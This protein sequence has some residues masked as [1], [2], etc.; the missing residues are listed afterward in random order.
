MKRLIIAVLVLAAVLMIQLTIVNGIA[1]PGGGIPDLVLLCVIAIGLTSGPEAGLAAGF[2]AGLALDLAPPAHQLVGQY[3]L[4][5]CLIGY[6][7]GR[8]WFTL[9]VSA[10]LALGVAAVAAV[11][12][13]VLTAGL[14]VAL[15]TP[16]VTLSAVAQTLP[17]AA[18]YDLG[19]SP[20]VLFLAVRLAVA[21][22]ANVGPADDS[23]AAEPGGSAQPGGLAGPGGLR[24][25]RPALGRGGPGLASGSWLTGDAAGEAGAVGA[26]GWLSGPATSRRARRE[27]ARLTAMVTGAAARKGAFWVG[28][29][30]DGLTPGPA[31]RA[32]CARSHRPA[33]L[34]PGDGVAG[35]A[36]RAG[37]PHPV[38]PSRPV[39]LRLAEQQRKNAARR[40][41]GA[42]ART[43]AGAGGSG[44]GRMGADVMGLGGHGLD[45][46]G[47]NGPG[48]PRIAFGTGSLPGAGRVQRSG[49]P[50]IAFGTGSLAAAGGRTAC[51][52]SGVRRGV[53]R[54]GV[55]SIAFGTGSLPGT[56][57]PRRTAAP[58]IAFGTGSLPGTLAPRRTAAPKIAFGTGSLPGTLAP[59]RTA[60][61]KI[62]FGTGSLHK[63]GR[64]SPGRP[65][66]P[67]FRSG[68][69]RSASGPWL[70]A[71]GFRSAG[72][73]SGPRLAAAGI[74][75]AGPYR[76]RRRKQP[77]FSGSGPSYRVIYSRHPKTASFRPGSR[78]LRWLPWANRAGGRS[79]VWRIGSRRVGGSS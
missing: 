54:G 1:L 72:L 50:K 74:R 27:H 30:P 38:L 20:L 70:A 65:A 66:R 7:C 59:R 47:I 21:L 76:A 41:S 75:P 55:P 19:L 71:A 58:K 4:V 63:A 10:V 31:G 44:L 23:P 9:R 34:R 79:T 32:S 28:R 51:G 12:G 2:F 42:G 14:A 73:A 33:K 56:L 35:S 22:G 61:P 48:L 69:A 40:A 3:A 62:A 6:C 52:V 26:I 18:L 43:G 78:S 16:E 57:A 8:L 36:T 13:E 29:R 67:R 25:L 64:T 49:V 11:V 17:S 5:L 46:H 77:K 60:A 45:R 15:D 68:T 37:R 39:R 53:R 24:R